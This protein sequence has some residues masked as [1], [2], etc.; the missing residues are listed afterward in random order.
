MFIFKFCDIVK[1]VE[2]KKKLSPR[3]KTRQ[4]EM[5]VGIEPLIV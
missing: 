5:F 4:L 1:I 2:R 3:R